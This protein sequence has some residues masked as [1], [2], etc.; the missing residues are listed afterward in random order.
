MNVVYNL[1]EALWYLSGRCDLSMIGYYAPGMGTYSADGHML[2]GTAYGRALFTRGQD[3][4]TQWDRVLDLLRRDPDSKRAVLGFFR[5][6]ELVELV[7]QVNPDVSC[8]IAAQFMLRE[9]RLHLTSYVR[10]NDAYTGME[11]AATLLGV[12]VGHYTHHVGSMHVNEPHYKSV[13]RVLNE[14]NQEDYRRPTFTP[15][16]MP[17]SSW[18]HEVRAVLKQEEALRTNAVQHTSASVKAT[19]LPSYWQQIL[20]VFEAYRQI[21]HTDQPITSN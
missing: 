12:Q 17:T 13:R 21:K 2:T 18:W 19:G 16:V 5:P 7:E 3:G 4:H 8:T 20:L 10:G 9:N 11:F 6:N 15:P 1:A 14:V